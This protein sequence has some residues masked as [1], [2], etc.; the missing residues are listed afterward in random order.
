MPLLFALIAGTTLG[1]AFERGDMCFHST[2]RGLFRRPRQLDLFRAYL[3]EF[4]Q[5]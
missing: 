2:L 1:Y 5:N 4:M 3:L